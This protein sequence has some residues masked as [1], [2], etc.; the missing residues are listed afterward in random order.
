MI[1]LPLTGAPNGFGL[2]HFADQ[3][4]LI[5]EWEKFERDFGGLLA[6][7]EVITLSNG[8][9]AVRF[10]CTGVNGSDI[11]SEHSE[12]AR[13]ITGEEW[14]ALQQGLLG[15][16]SRISDTLAGFT[17]QEASRV[18]SL[19]RQELEPGFFRY[20]N[21]SGARRL[22]VLWGVYSNKIG[23]PLPVGAKDIPGNPKEDPV[24]I[25]PPVVPL[26]P[27]GQIP[28]GNPSRKSFPAVLPL[29]LG[30]LG[31]LGLLG[32]LLYLLSI[33]SCNTRQ[34]KVPPVPHPLAVLDANSDTN[35]SMWIIQLQQAS[36]KISRLEGEL[37]TS[38]SQSADK[39]DAL[40]NQLNKVQA[41]IARLRNDRAVQ[42]QSNESTHIEFS[43]KSNASETLTQNIAAQMPDSMPARP[44]VVSDPENM[45]N[46]DA[47]SKKTKTSIGHQKTSSA[48]ISSNNSVGPEEFVAPCSEAN[49]NDSN[50]GIEK[51]KSLSES[52]VFQASSVLQNQSSGGDANAGSSA[53][54]SRSIGVPGKGPLDDPAPAFPGGQCPPKPHSNDIASPAQ[55]PE[56][57]PYM[58]TDSIFLPSET[59]TSLTHRWEDLDDDSAFRQTW[60]GPTPPQLHLAITNDYSVKKFKHIVTDGNGNQIINQ[61]VEWVY[62]RQ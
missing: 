53:D 60:D 55:P 45:A 23:V 48:T 5:S 2:I 32:L 6:H 37:L 58:P 40:S 33:M 3:K 28:A 52:A 46:N 21:D 9:H 11:L 62:E 50:R 31:L 56:V 24:G 15:V 7:P 20:C 36:N 59:G 34:S 49:A 54:G 4:P 44:A 13:Q 12:I 38:K 19:P 30:G 27:V 61:E 8:Q 17:L 47:L 14:T 35:E 57:S 22:V 25:L 18:F 1:E 10:S 51:V 41:E 43:V 42:A 26:P 16:K 29:I 39:I